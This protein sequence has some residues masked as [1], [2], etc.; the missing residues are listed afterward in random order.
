MLIEPFDGELLRFG[1]RHGINPVVGDV[2][3]DDQPLLRALE[4][5]ISIDH[6]GAVVEELLVAGKYDLHRAIRRETDRVLPQ[7]DRIDLYEVRGCGVILS[8]AGADIAL[9][10]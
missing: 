2:G 8:T 5:V 10:I 9:P 4:P 7:V 3:D 6:R 1:A